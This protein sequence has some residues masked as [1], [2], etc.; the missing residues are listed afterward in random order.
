MFVWLYRLSKPKPKLRLRNIIK[1]T[2][3]AYI[4]LYTVHITQCA[5]KTSAQSTKSNKWDK[6][7][8]KIDLK[9]E[10][11]YRKFW[12][13]NLIQTQLY[14]GSVNLDSQTNKLLTAHKLQSTVYTI[15]HIQTIYMQQVSKP[16]NSKGRQPI[17]NLFWDLK[18][19]LLWALPQL[20]YIYFQ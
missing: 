7:Q 17:W 18:A 14:L 13:E 11:L 20:R 12:I 1:Y 3:C 10:L 9:F 4:T 5:I 15:Q 8:E 19:G 2:N 16:D 6:T